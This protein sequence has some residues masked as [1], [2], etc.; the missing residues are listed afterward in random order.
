MIEVLGPVDPEGDATGATIH[1]KVGEF[2]RPVMRVIAT[3]TSADVIVAFYS[4][5]EKGVAELTHH[6]DRSSS[7]S[8]TRRRFREAIEA[9]TS[10]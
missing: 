2:A 7:S 9:G 5:T 1:V 10:P 4:S 8:A 3:I 6:L